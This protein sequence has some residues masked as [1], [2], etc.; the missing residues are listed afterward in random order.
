MALLANYRA[1]TVFAIGSVALVI[2]LLVFIGTLG[3]IANFVSA[4]SDSGLAAA[5][6]VFLSR[7]VPHD[8]FSLAM[9]TLFI[10]YFIAQVR[11]VS[12]GW[13][14]ILII[15]LVLVLPV[16]I[17]L[18]INHFLTI[19]FSNVIGALPAGIAIATGLSLFVL[20][21]LAPPSATFLYLVRRM[22]NIHTRAADMPLLLAFM[23]SNVAAIFALTQVVI[24]LTMQL[25]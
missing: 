22:K 7:P 24:I 9:F 2:A 14:R 8:S 13:K 10:C 3:R 1:T 25:P 6:D 19:G 5:I 4:L 16:A 12:E 15:S 21:V 23:W 11:L 18:A 20:I 17:L